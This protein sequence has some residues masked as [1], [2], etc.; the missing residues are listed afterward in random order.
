M[1]TGS[2]SPSLTYK[3]KHT[4][5]HTPSVLLIYGI[6]IFNVF[7]S[8]LQ[9]PGSTV[10]DTGQNVRQIKLKTAGG[11]NGGKFLHV[12]EDFLYSHGDNIMS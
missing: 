3:H 9:I 8:F 11:K 6:F 2:L 10:C 5:S 4:H 12:G 1:Y 7:I